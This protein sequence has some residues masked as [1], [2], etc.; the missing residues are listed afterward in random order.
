ML[1]SVVGTQA[2]EYTTPYD[3]NLI[4]EYNVAGEM[5]GVLPLQEKLGVRVLA[6]IT[7]DDRYLEVAS[8]HRAKLNVMIC[9]KALI[10]MAHK[11]EER[12]GIP[13]IEESIYGVEDVNQLLRNVTAKLGD[14]E[15]QARA[16]DL[17]QAET[18]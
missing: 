15:Q 4:G 1:E 16:E 6:K 14:P 7:V 3:I 9:S 12:Y 8:A 13:Y 5:W 17:I 11:M 18:A 10:N 2:P